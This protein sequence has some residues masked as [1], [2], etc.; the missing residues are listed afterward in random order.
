MKKTFKRKTRNTYRNKYR[1]H[2]KP[3]HLDT[4]SGMNDVSLTAST[5]FDYASICNQRSPAVHCCHQRRSTRACWRSWCDLAIPRDPDRQKSAGFDHGV[6]W[7][8]LGFLLFKNSKRKLQSIR[9]RR[10]VV[11]FPAKKLFGAMLRYAEHHMES[12]GII[13]GSRNWLQFGKTSSSDRVVGGVWVTKHWFWKR[14]RGKLPNRL[15][16]KAANI[17]QKS[18]A[19]DTNDIVWPHWKFVSQDLPHHFSEGCEGQ[20]SRTNIEQNQEDPNIQKNPEKGQ[21][22]QSCSIKPTTSNN[23]QQPVR[24]CIVQ[25]TISSARSCAHYWDGHPLGMRLESMESTDMADVHGNPW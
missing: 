3:W 12:Y 17:G 4:W 5:C 10:C 24:C 11:Y 6:I 9:K 8:S 23:H 18:R 19:N 7:F 1:N 20:R 2:M 21:R 14:S 22:V 25:R 15:F 13:L 16:R